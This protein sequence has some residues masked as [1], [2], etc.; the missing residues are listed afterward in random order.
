VDGEVLCRFK[1]LAYAA[2]GFD[3]EILCM[4][5]GDVL[6]AYR[7]GEVEMLKEVADSVDPLKDKPSLGEET[8]I[9]RLLKL[10]AVY[11]LKENEGVRSEDIHVEE[12][13]REGPPD[14]RPDIWAYKQ[15]RVIV[16]D[17]KTSIGRLPHY[18]IA[19]AVEKY[20]DCGSEIWIVMRPITLILYT[21]KIVKTLRKLKEEKK[22]KVDVYVPTVEKR[23]VNY[24]EFVKRV[25]ECFRQCRNG[26]GPAA[27]GVHS[28]V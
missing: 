14:K 1:C 12:P 28:C 21:E 19:D 4:D 18:E 2:A 20:R 16:V 22:V 8:N 13:C 15:G 23:L 3:E 24:V 5:K 17:A 10:F 7:H 6:A 25:R 27:Y 9:H 26:V 11:H